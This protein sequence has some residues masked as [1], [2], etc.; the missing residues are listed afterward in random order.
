[1]LIFS[2]EI[3]CDRKSDLRAQVCRYTKRA[4]ELKC[5]LSFKSEVQTESSSSSSSATCKKNPKSKLS[6]TSNSPAASVDEVDGGVPSTSHSR[7]S[8]LQT[9]RKRKLFSCNFKD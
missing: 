4:E 9:L 3:N 5:G 7:N 2:D 8:S 1:M 6:E